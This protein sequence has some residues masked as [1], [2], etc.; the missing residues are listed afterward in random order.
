MPIEYTANAIKRRRLTK[1]L[2]NRK[3]GLL[4][5]GRMDS[6][7][8]YH[9]EQAIRE[10][11]RDDEDPQPWDDELLLTSA[12]MED[13]HNFILDYLTPSDI[14]GLAA[15]DSNLNQVIETYSNGQLLKKTH[16]I[17]NFKRF[18]RFLKEFRG[19]KSHA[20]RGANRLVKLKNHAERYKLPRR[21]VLVVIKK[22][23]TL[24]GPEGKPVTI[25]K[26]KHKNVQGRI[27]AKTGQCYWVRTKSHPLCVKAEFVQPRETD[28]DGE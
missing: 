26:G 1:A 10:S 18:L 2:S 9:L 16:E 8:D 7:E 27:A 28:S 19:G 17:A 24:M 25:I 12:P 22:Q 20:Y 23:E 5:P 6:L 15:V 14:C 13:V 4:T 21:C 3:D 11:V